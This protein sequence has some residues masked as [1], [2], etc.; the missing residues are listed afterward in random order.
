MDDQP[1]PPGGPGQYPPP[2][3][4]PPS[5]LRETVSSATERIQVIIEAAEKAASGI[6]EDAEAQARRYLDDSRRRADMLAEQRL[7]A[8]AEVTDSLLQQAETVKRQSDDL[9]ASLDSARG[10]IENRDRPDL[11]GAAPSE[12]QGFERP[13]PHLHP[14][15]PT[16]PNLQAV[17]PAPGPQPGPEATPFQPPAMPQQPSEPSQPSEPPQVAP[18]PA[19]P[20]QGTDPTGAMPSPGP[21]PTGADAQGQPPASGRPTMDGA[22]VLATQMAVAGSTRTEIEIRLRDEFGIADARP[23]L[24]G[25]LGP[26]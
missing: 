1:T 26:E 2:P 4:P 14:V 7:R 23:I 9:I 8:M 15:E 10:Q 12:P 20:P 22:R 17:P 13:G 18:P 21:E 6:I 11:Y 16:P 19:A 5:P 25:I 3:P 24:D